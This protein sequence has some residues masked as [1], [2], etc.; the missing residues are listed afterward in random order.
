MIVWLA[1]YPRSGNTLLRLVLHHVFG[2]TTYS[3]YDDPLFVEMGASQVIGHRPLPA[4]VAD[5]AGREETFLVKTHELPA[6]R[7]RAIYLAR[8][9]RDALVSYARYIQ[10]FEVPPEGRAADDAGREAEFRNILRGLIETDTRY[11]GWSGHVS[12]WLG[13]GAAPTATIRFEDLLQGP[14]ETARRALEAV[15]LP[16]RSTGA[17]PPTFEEL[18]R[19]W[20]KFFRSGQVGAW[21]LEMGWRLHRRFW[22]RHGAAMQALGYPRQGLGGRSTGT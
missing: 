7:W 12:A 8:D 20:P 9:G 2:L 4:P 17:A 21:R 6:E 19:R 13:R 18:H 3:A 16:H 11:G 15:G 5:L 14:V 10:E 1:S 22:R